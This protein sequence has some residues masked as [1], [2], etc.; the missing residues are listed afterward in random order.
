M[1]METS[2]ITD[3]EQMGSCICIIKGK[4]WMNGRHSNESVETVKTEWMGNV[5][6][7]KCL[8][9]RKITY[10]NVSRAFYLLTQSW[11]LPGFDSCY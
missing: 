11:F 6:L 7:M 10:V 2:H 3:I 4:S 1:T 8:T 5:K 9:N